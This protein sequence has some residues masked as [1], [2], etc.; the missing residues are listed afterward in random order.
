[1]ICFCDG[2]GGAD[3]HATAP[4]RCQM[5]APAQAEAA[6]ILSSCVYFLVLSDLILSNLKLSNKVLRNFSSALPVSV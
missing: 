4:G 1:L 2:A 5:R 6:S 3:I